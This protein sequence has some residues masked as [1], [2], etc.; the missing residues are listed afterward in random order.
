MLKNLVLIV[1]SVCLTLISC[2]LVIRYTNQ[3]PPFENALYVP[4]YLTERDLSLRWR[5][6]PTDGRNSLGLRNRE[7]SPKKT[8]TYRILFLGDSL[9]WSG[10]TS[11]GQLYTEV[12][13]DRLN[14]RFS[15][16]D[17]LFEVINAGIPG[18]TTYQELEF[19]RI[20]GIDMEPDLVILGFVFNDL[21]YKYLHKPSKKK[22]LGPDPTI[23]LNRFNPDAFPASLFARSYLA[24]DVVWRSERIWKR[25]RQ[26]PAFPF[27]QKKDFFLAW[28]DYGWNRARKLIGEMRTLLAERGSSLVILVFPVSDQ[29]NDQYRA[30]D[31]A[32]VLYPQ[33]KIREIGDE[34][35]IPMLN[36]T[37][38]IYKNGGITLFRDYLH[39][40]A[41][42]NDIV[43]NELEKYLVNKLNP[44]RSR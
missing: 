11:S 27:E 31:E 33:A 4:S 10:E 16:R 8:G 14:S 38:S 29:V 41:K 42:G 15:N 39:M 24:H 22:L 2:E 43:A 6:S 17:N 44:G 13:E 20:Y 36:L 37:E 19:L 26:S 7:L 5:F 40:N 32:Y 1:S 21:Y 23:H 3:A 30:I 28:K 18:Y 9:I 25:L 12:L 35:A 34:Y